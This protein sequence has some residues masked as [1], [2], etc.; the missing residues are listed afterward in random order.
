MKSILIAT[1]TL[2][3]LNSF[4]DDHTNPVNGTEVDCPH[5]LETGRNT[6]TNPEKETP[7]HSTG[8]TKVIR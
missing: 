3:A 5:K 2:L 8:T 1:I 7:A 4:G 6:D